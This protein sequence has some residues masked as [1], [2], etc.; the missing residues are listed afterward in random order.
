MNK[1]FDIIRVLHKF[2][3]GELSFEEKALLD[4]WME[5]PENRK[6][7]EELLTEEREEAVLKEFQKYDADRAYR[8]F[9][10][11]N[12]HIL[13]RRRMRRVAA[14]MI[15]F[16]L[17]AALFL[18]IS[19][20]R[21][22]VVTH[23]VAET[24]NPGEAKAILTLAGGEKV[25]LGKQDT[26]FQQATGG[27]WIR[28]DSSGLTYEKDLCRPEQLVYNELYVPRRGE[29][30]LRLADG[31]RIYVNADS[32]LKYP[33]SFAADCREVELSGEAY[34]EIARDTLRPFIVKVGDMRVQV[35][36][37]SFNV[38]A[39]KLSQEVKTTLVSGKVKV[40]YK[41]V[42]L[43]LVPGEQACVS[44]ENGEIYKKQVN[45][46]L[47]TAWK[48]GLFKFERE[49]LENIMLILSRWYDVNVFFRNEALKQSLFS[50]DLKK[51]DTIEQHLQMLEM[52]TNVSFV[53]QGNHVFVGYKN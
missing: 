28:S 46:A 40:G 43:E 19:E 10:G 27:G 13:L 42:Q 16:I 3:Q 2:K 52:T 5:V 48:D 51:Y 11:K 37:T 31:S 14:V 35:L 26:R 4:S 34:F 45:V 41:Q 7:A 6:F 20:S 9:V 23:E 25:V 36:G 12:S 53:V 39:Y 44:E 15:P 22:N 21:K 30:S 8:R 38:N 24:V 29:F 50:G 47:Y 18:Y 33:E 1:I 17:S 49:S 32:Y